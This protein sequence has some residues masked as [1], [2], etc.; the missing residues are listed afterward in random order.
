MRTLAALT[1]PS[2]SLPGRRGRAEVPSLWRDY[3]VA[4]YNFSFNL[5]V[6]AKR[7]MRLGGPRP[8]RRALRAGASWLI[9]IW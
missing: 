2:M 1:S 7:E 8:R 4:V 3:A 9:V 5:S 6:Q